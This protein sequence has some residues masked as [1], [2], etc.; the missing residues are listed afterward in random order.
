MKSLRIHIGV[1]VLALFGLILQGNAQESGVLAFDDYQ[2]VRNSSST[3]VHEIRLPAE[4]MMAIMG[5]LNDWDGMNNYFNVFGTKLIV[6]SMEHNGD[7]TKQVV[8]RREDGRDFYNL[9]PTLT[10]KF[11]PLE[12]GL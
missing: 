12:K 7:G 1:M 3:A 5:G 6:E 2:S 8:L 11:I 4:D 10:A 9:F